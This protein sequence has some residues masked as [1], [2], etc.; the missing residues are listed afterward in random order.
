VVGLFADTVVPGLLVA[1]AACGLTAALARPS[2]ETTTAPARMKPRDT[3]RAVAEA[4][5]KAAPS[6]GKLFLVLQRD[7][8]RGHSP[9]RMPPPA[10]IHVCVKNHS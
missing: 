9:L 7:R 8:R 2:G 5:R 10:L 4:A 1:P 6:V 3:S